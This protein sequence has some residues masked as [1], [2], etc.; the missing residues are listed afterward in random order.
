LAQTSVKIGYALSRT[1]PNA[2]GAAVTTLPNY[3]LL[4]KE[5]NAAGGLKLGD[6]VAYGQHCALSDAAL[7]VARGE[8]VVMLGANGAG[9]T[10]LLKAIAGIVPAL[11]GKRVTLGGRDLST[12]PPHAIVE[13]GLALVPEGR[14]IFGELTVAENLLL[15]AN[16]KRAR[17]GEAKRRAN[18]LALFPRLEERLGQT[19]RTMSGGEQQMVAIGRALMSNPEI[20][21]L[22]EPSLGLSPRLV[23]ELFAALSKIRD[24]GVGLLLVE[25]NARESL[26]IANRGDLLENGMIVGSGSPAELRSD[27]AVRRAY[28]GGLA[29]EAP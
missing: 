6:S 26:A 16:P 5:V 18:V 29:A 19:V 21:L 23:H 3:E 1:G 22:D 12:L 20:L 27:N 15:G 14:G 9:K 11:P 7:S 17:S 8:I 25:Q 13:A 24:A 2:G 4:V 10:T 28:L